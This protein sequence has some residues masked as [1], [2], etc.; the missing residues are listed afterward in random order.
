MA[1]STL[2][3]KNQIVIPKEAREALGLKSGDKLLIVVRNKRV[4]VLQKPE[5][6]HRAIRGLAKSPYSSRYLDKERQSWD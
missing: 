1:V 5:S 6:P 3:S 2:S 4:V